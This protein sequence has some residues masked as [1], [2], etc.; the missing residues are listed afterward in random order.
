VPEEAKYKYSGRSICSSAKTEPLTAIF[1]GSELALRFLK[2][3]DS[4]LREL[5]GLSRGYS[6]KVGSFGRLLICGRNIA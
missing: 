2:E 1:P 5:N 6:W 4:D 3:Y